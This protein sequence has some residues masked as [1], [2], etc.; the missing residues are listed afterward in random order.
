M[1]LKELNLGDRL[2]IAIMG[3]DEEFSL[4]K[5][6][7]GKAF[8]LLRT[9][10]Q[11][12]AFGR[13]NTYKGSIID[14][15]LQTLYASIMEE[16]FYSRIIPYDLGG[17]ERKI[18]L[19]SEEEYNA[20]PESIRGWECECVYDDEGDSD[21]DRCPK[22]CVAWTRTPH[23][24]NSNNVRNVNTDGSLNNNNAYNGNNGVR[25]D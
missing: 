8:F 9:P 24:S 19:P 17:Y 13:C 6:E 7:D 16:E 11:F 14:K 10:V 25:P 18:W 20:M 2:N 15:Y 23:A 3:E 22:V 5:V 1:K 21:C 12:S 4:F